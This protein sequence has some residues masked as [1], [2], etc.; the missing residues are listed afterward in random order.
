MAGEEFTNETF[1]DTFILGVGP[2]VRDVSLS[3]HQTIQVRKENEV[4]IP[5]PGYGYLRTPDDDEP[6]AH[7]VTCGAPEFSDNLHHRYF[8]KGDCDRCHNF[9]CQCCGA[10]L[11]ANYGLMLD[12][13]KCCNCHAL[14]LLHPTKK[15]YEYVG[16][17]EVPTVAM[18]AR[19]SNWYI[20]IEHDSSNLC[21]ICELNKIADSDKT[22]TNF[23]PLPTT[24][25]LSVSGLVNR[26]AASQVEL[27]ITCGVVGA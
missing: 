11:H 17:S 26:S 13:R 16:H 24:A 3:S 9:K 12:M 6:D 18:C 14:Y 2:A 23:V 4:M 1:H 5:E 10:F 19:C 22:N 20:A 8:S 25:G 15:V 7:C 21:G 27:P